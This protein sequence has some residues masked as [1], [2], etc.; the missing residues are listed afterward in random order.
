MT[1]NDDN[2]ETIRENIA[3][4]HIKLNEISLEDTTELKLQKY[5]ARIILD[6]KYD[7]NMTQTCVEIILHKF[8]QY[9]NDA[10]DISTTQVFSMKLI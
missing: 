2:M 1:T 10:L 3:E 6:V 8:K 4:E 7:H 9:F 5:L